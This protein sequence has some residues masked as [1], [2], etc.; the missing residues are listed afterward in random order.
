[1]AQNEYVDEVT[2]QNEVRVFLVGMLTH[3]WQ[4]FLMRD[5]QRLSYILFSPMNNSC[6]VIHSI[7]L[8][9]KL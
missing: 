6:G 9:A 7:I 3:C 2:E 5:L 4:S 8:L 1:M